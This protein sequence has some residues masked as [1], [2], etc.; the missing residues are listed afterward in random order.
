MSDKASGPSNIANMVNSKSLKVLPVG[1][2]IKTVFSMPVTN[3]S[4][5]A[6]ER[7][8]VIDMPAMINNKRLISS[9]CFE[10]LIK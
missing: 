5:I 1:I 7:R 8:V 6:P 4:V 10:V 2:S 3:W 9:R